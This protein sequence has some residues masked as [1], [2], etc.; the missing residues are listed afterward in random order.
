M[1]VSMIEFS[2]APRSWANRL[3]RPESKVRPQPSSDPLRRMSFEVKPL[4]RGFGQTLGNALRR[5]LL[6]SLPGAAVTSIR[7]EGVDHEF[8]WVHGV[9]EDVTEI[10]LN[11]KSLALQMQQTEAPR[12]MHLRAE[13]PK[14]VFARDIV[15]PSGVRILNPDLLICTMDSGA[16][17]SME[18][19]AEVGVGYVPAERN[20]VENAPIGLIPVDSIFNPVRGSA[21]QVAN[22]RVRDDTDFEEL[23]IDIET[24]G[25]ITPE[26]AL[27]QAASIIHNQ[28]QI[29]VGFDH[30]EAE[31]K[32]ET[33]LPFNPNFLRK[34]DELELSVRSANCLKNENVV[35]IGDLVL[36]TESDMM[37]TPNFGRK[38]LNEIKDVLENMGLQLGMEV[39]GWPPD[40]IEELR[41][42]S[43]Y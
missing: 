18:L 40:N 34:V 11:I 33:K 7:I 43:S 14:E 4:V 27:T 36:K 35:Y 23:N 15:T 31:V 39:P 9:R 25:S 38:S 24:D 6:S 17:L 26:E 28:L 5:T 32:T 2:P 8:S 41:S 20:A 37:M 30:K 10:I 13:G 12:K 21:F 3:V 19:T 16:T 1:V 22:T 42:Q 29:F